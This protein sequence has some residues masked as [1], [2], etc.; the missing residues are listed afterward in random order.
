MTDKR[1]KKLKRAELLEMLLEQTREVERLR[2]RLNVAEAALRDRRLKTE[3]AGDLA[4]AVLEVNEVMAAAQTTAQQ[5]LDN[6]KMMHEE[7]EEKCNRMIAEAQKI[8]D[9]IKKEAWTEAKLASKES[10]VISKDSNE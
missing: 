8:A 10:E 9:E 4:H 7:A 3:K 5:Y 6:I 2:D 1:L